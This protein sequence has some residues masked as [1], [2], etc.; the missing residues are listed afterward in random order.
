M[1]NNLYSIKEAAEL[2]GISRAYVYYL[3]NI[4]KIKA[5]KI[6]SQYVVGQKEI[7]RYKDEHTP[8]SDS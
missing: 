1:N 4:G 3:K 2:L 8:K 7:D 5:K 6:G